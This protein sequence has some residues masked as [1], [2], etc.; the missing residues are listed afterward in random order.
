MD[1]CTFD[2][3]AKWDNQQ[4]GFPR[5]QVTRFLHRQRE[6]DTGGTGEAIPN[7]VY[8]PGDRGEMIFVCPIYLWRQSRADSVLWYII[9]HDLAEWF[10]TGF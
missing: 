6:S 2:L 9:E 5:D 8:L 7:G 4:A 10:Y 1:P 3:H